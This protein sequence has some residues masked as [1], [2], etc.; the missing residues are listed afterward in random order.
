MVQKGVRGW[1]LPTPAHQYVVLWHRVNEQDCQ[2]VAHI[3][4]RATEA[5]L[6]NAECHLGYAWVSFTSWIRHLLL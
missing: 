1:V 4:C 5:N 3:L 6:S 2:Q